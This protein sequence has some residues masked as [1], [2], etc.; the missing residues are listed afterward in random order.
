MRLFSGK[1]SSFIKRYQNNFEHDVIND[2]VFTVN[3]T[4]MGSSGVAKLQL[5]FL[6]TGSYNC[7]VDWGDDSFDTITTYNQAETLHTYSVGAVY[8][9][10]ISGFFN[11]FSFANTGDKLKLITIPQFGSFKPIDVQGAFFGC[12]NFTGGFT[13]AL[14]LSLCNT[15]RDMFSGCSFFNEDIDSWNVSTITSLYGTFNFCSI[16]NRD[17]NSWD[18]SSNT[19]LTNTFASATLFN[20]DIRDWDVSN[21][22]DMYRTF[23]LSSFNQPLNNWDVSSCG[24]FFHFIYGTPFNQP[25]AGWA[26]KIIASDFNYMFMGAASFNQSLSSWDISS[27]TTMVETFYNCTAFNQSLANWDVSNVLYMSNMFSYCGMNTANYDLLWTGWTGW[28]T[29]APTITLKNNVSF[30]AIGRQYSLGSDAEAA[31]AYLIATKTWTVVDS[32]GI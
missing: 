20:G 26:N 5:P 15:M 6:V 25:L 24:S 29:G 13:D 9:V 7:V 30:G 16:F 3:T 8:T 4:V 2:F 11:I 31:R 18:T 1:K 23:I 21:V 14:D 10:T 22:T 12:A 17:L 19:N 32:G 27:V 28:T